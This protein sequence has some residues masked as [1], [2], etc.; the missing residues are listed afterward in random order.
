MTAPPL[1][2]V[3][4][5]APAAGM[6]KTR[7]AATIGAHAAADV[8]RELVATTLAH[9]VAARARG[10]VADVE[11]WCAPDPDTAYFHALA[12]ATNVARRRQC[13]GDL[14]MRMAD[15]LA[16]ALT[17]HAHVLL[18]GTDCPLLDP[19][20]IADAAQALEGHDA[21]LV[22]AEDGGYVLVGAAR[23]LPF[24]GVRWSTP[25]A[26]SDTL[27]AFARARLRCALGA[28]LWDVD[29]A[30]DLARWNALRQR[31]PEL[32]ATPA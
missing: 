1:L 11:L 22:P 15:A 3:F 27:A 17:R 18:A 16:D 29:D 4:A 21:V 2:L 10:I 6:V 5:K 32:P 19:Q 13:D 7:L 14:G 28:T 8:Y 20:R 23:P 24:A 30:A 9:A 12:G 31:A 25:D 26:L